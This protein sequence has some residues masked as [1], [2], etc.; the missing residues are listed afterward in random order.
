MPS[1]MNY[2][3]FLEELL[4]NITASILQRSIS[5]LMVLLNSGKIINTGIFLPSHWDGKSLKKIS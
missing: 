5:V 1:L 4:I 2:N 3:P